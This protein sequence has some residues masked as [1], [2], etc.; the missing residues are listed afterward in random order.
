[1]SKK[2]VRRV[3][4]TPRA[5][6]DLKNIGRYT[7]RTWGN[8]QRNHYLKS[9]E[10]CFKSLAEDPFLGRHRT[11]ICEGYYSLPKGQHVVFYLIGHETID[12]IGIPH[13][14]MDTINYFS[15]S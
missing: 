11:D 3:R 2:L 1:M 8:S 14:N 5:Y 13:K 9:L 12:M 10:T 7:E 6:D 15:E 4:V